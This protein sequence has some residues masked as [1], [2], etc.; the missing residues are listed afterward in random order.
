M[1]IKKKVIKVINKYETNDPFK[2]C[3]S[4]GI[5]IIYENLGSILGYYSKHFR[6]PIIHLNQ[7]VSEKQQI[8]VCAH[9][10]GHAI[11][12]PEH[13]TSFLKKHTFFSTDIYEIEANKFA[14]NL[15]FS[16]KSLTNDEI[17]DYG[18]PN[19]FLQKNFYHFIEHTFCE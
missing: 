17:K 13:N 14:V 19:D 8:F 11:L 12:H 15:L 9:E 1:Y 6:I 5:H 10:L 3:K 16:N 18:I 7:N 4:M 2:I